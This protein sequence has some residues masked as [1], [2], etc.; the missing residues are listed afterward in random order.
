MRLTKLN[1]VVVILSLIPAAAQAAGAGRKGAK[2]M[3]KSDQLII[4]AARFTK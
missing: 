2:I 4:R 3:P 1:A